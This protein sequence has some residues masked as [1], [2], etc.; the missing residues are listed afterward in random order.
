MGLEARQA[1]FLM[2]LSKQRT[3]VLLQ[4]M[5]CSGC[6]KEREKKRSSLSS[7]QDLTKWLG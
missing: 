2:R 6:A 3:A 4:T 7:M 1:A 5:K